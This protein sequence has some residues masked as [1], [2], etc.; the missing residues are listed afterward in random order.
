VVYV[1]AVTASGFL[2]YFFISFMGSS[3]SMI[4]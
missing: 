4:A 3:F 1:Q 2:L